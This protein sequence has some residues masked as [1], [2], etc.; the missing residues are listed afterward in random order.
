ME[1]GKRERLFSLAEL[2]EYYDCSRRTFYTWIAKGFLPPAKKVFG[3]KRWSMSEIDA[4]I[5]KGETK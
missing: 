1:N 4:W 5:K 2:C 3:Q